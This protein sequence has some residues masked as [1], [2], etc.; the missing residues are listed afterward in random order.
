MGQAL[1]IYKPRRG[2]APLW[3]FPPGTLYKREYASFVL[4][5]ALGWDFIPP[6]AIASGPYGIGSM[7]LY[8]ESDSSVS[9][10][11]L[12]PEWRLSLQRI[13]TFDWIANNA[14]RKSS[15]CFVGSAGRMW[16]IDHGLT[17]NAQAKLRTVIWAF[18]G[19][20]IP[21]SIMAD[22][23]ALRSNQFRFDELIRSLG[24]LLDQQEVGSFVE[25]YKSLTNSGQFPK[26]DPYKNIPFGFW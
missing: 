8:V 3:D 10:Q 1:A 16:G 25:R 5:R 21:D 22:L 2:E 9:L 12:G 4:A 18:D 23:S 26:M 20:T 24:S 19:E 7:Q 14:D 17:F 6:T 13:M 11:G 15:H